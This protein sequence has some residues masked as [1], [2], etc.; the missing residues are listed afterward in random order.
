[1]NIFE[2]IVDRKSIIENELANKD[3]QAHEVD[4]LV[5]Q[6]NIDVGKDGLDQQEE[7]ELLD[8]NMALDD[9]MMGEFQ[10]KPSQYIIKKS[11]MPENIIDEYDIKLL[12]D[13]LMDDNLKFKCKP[14]KWPNNE[15]I[16]YNTKNAS[17]CSDERLFFNI[18]E[19]HHVD[20]YTIKSC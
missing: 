15:N 3:A 10:S 14:R 16:I 18:L 11:E 2:D 17:I 20:I 5:V 4:N 9:T 6:F 8:Q 1:M 19:Q 13:A 7:F 12:E